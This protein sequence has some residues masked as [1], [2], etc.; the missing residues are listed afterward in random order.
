MKDQLISFE[1]A[2]L[3]KEKGYTN[4][5]N[6]SY[7]FALNEQVHE[8]DGTSGPFGWEKGECNLQ[9]FYMRNNTKG[10][11][12]SNDSWYLCE[13]PTQSLLQKWLRD[14]HGVDFIIRPQIGE[15]K[16]YVCDPIN[17]KLIAQDT[18]EEALEA[19]LVNALEKLQE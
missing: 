8:E 14:E 15:T 4:G 1:T 18:Y 12:S 10:I 17:H 5:S 7:E 3:A 11:D 6:M 2:K 19:C 9:A 16:Q 13:A